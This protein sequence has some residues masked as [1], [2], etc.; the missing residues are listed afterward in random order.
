MNHNNKA[1]RYEEPILLHRLGDMDRWQRAVFAATCAEYLL[2]LYQ[3]FRRETGYG[4][5][6]LVARALDLLWRVL[7][8]EKG[9]ETDFW[10]LAQESVDIVPDAREPVRTMWSGYEQHAIFAEAYAL[11]AYASGSVQESVWAARQVVD[12]A[13]MY[14]T[15]TTFPGTSLPRNARQK[16]DAHPVVQR[17]LRWLYRDLDE[18]EQGAT[19]DKALAERL[20]SRAAA[21]G[22]RFIPDQPPMADTTPRQ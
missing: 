21:E 15:I 11:R 1:L 16:I 8:G 5:P 12:A 7:S 14:A 20:R 17:S 18:I 4:N 19:G 2:P 22:G 10:S 9:F 6:D 13:D 3:R